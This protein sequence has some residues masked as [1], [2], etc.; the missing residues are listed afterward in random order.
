MQTVVSVK[1]PTASDMTVSGT[2]VSGDEPGDAHHTR[3]HSENRTTNPPARAV[4]GVRRGATLRNASPVLLVPQLYQ[5]ARFR[6]TKMDC[7]ALARC[8]H[9]P[10]PH[11]PAHSARRQNGTKMD[12]IALARCTHTPSAQAATPPRPAAESRAVI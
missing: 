10:L 1:K 7:I 3:Y 12:C 4:F 11:W 9:P 2:E 5:P 8:T 6:S